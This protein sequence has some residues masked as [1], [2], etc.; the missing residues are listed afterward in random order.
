MDVSESDGELVVTAELPGMNGED[1]HIDPTDNVLTI[2]GEKKEEMEREEKEM[3]VYERSYGS[4]RRSFMLSSPVDEAKVG[5]EFRDGVLKV[6]LPRVEK[7]KGREIQVESGR[8]PARAPRR[9]A[10]RALLPAVAPTRR[11]ASRPMSKRR[12]RGPLVDPLLVGREQVEEEGGEAG[13]LQR[14]G[15]EG[16]CRGSGAAIPD[17][18]GPSPLRLRAAP[19]AVG[20]HGRPACTRACNVAS[21]GATGVGGP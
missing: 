17:R 10:G 18:S 12:C 7:A 1:V 4:F 20:G 15:D 5:A 3:R 9:D 11:S 21:Q 6:T 13:P 8:R 16:G 2:R 19:R 14:F